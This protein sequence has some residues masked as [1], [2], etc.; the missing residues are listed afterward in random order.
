MSTMFFFVF[1]LAGPLLQALQEKKNL[2][3]YGNPSFAHL[4]LLAIFPPTQG[5]PVM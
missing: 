2:D 5:P 3:K 1:F 4:H